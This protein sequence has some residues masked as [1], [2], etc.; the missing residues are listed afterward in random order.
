MNYRKLGKTGIQVSEM[1][2][3]QCLHYCLTRPGVACVLAGAHTK[4][5]LWKRPRIRNCLRNR[6]ITRRSSAAPLPTGSRISACTADIAPLH[7]GNR[8][9]IGQ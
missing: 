2:V 6:R 7:R 9:C 3:P 4:S 1:T 5:S 8:H